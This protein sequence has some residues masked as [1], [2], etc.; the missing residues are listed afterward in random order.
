[1]KYSIFFSWL[2]LALFLPGPGPESG[3]TPPA[4]A[5]VAQESSGP[6]ELAPYVPSPM[7]VVEAM[8]EIAGVTDKDVVYDLGAGDGRVVITAAKKYGAR[9][10]GFEIDP[11]LVARAR[12]T[13]QQEGVAHL[14]EIR[15]QDMTTADLSEATVVTLYLYPEAN[16]LLRPI[17][18]RQLPRGARVVASQF[19]MGDWKP[20]AFTDVTIADNTEAAKRPEDAY[21]I[22]VLPRDYTVYLF[23]IDNH[24]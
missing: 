10:V 17:L 3:A 14:V 2:V 11:E 15:E 18:V 12:R 24:R 21:W 4:K 7:V 16:M 6:V 19:T 9:A 1:M 13:A 5:T 23:R 8:L 22:D 20:D